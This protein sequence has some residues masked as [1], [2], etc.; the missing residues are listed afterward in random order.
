M[1][2]DWNLVI[3]VTCVTH[4]E[5]PCLVVGVLS[6]SYSKSPRPCS[7]Y[8]ETPKRICPED[9]HLQLD[10]RGGMSWAGTV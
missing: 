4:R 9:P 3:Q 5:I 6:S 2:S 1:H 7:R 8:N 10:K